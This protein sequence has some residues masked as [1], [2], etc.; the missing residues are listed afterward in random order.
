MLLWTTAL[1]PDRLI[2]QEDAANSGLIPQTGSGIATVRAVSGILHSNGT[3]RLL[4]DVRDVANLGAVTVQIDYDPTQIQPTACQRT[5]D[6][7]YGLCNRTIDRDS[8]STPDAVLFN[9]ISIAGRSAN[10]SAPLGL[11][12]ID[13]APVG[14]PVSGTVSALIVEVFT[15]TDVVG[16]PIAVVT[17]D[18]HI[19]HQD[20]PVFN[21]FL[22]F[23]ATNR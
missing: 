7:D 6:F 19:T 15:F 8:D 12:Q 2:A 23:L 20:P 13:W 10:A 14:T 9:V 11:M 21:L 4:V 22:P 18:G 3:T 17:E 1:L 5:S 16:I